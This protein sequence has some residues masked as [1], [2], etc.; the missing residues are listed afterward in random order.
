MHVAID[1]L[2]GHLQ[3]LATR[4]A[5]GGMQDRAMFGKVDFLTTEHGVTLR[6]DLPLTCQLK[7]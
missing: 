3:R 5:Q 4:C 7:Q 6:L 2:T 1:I